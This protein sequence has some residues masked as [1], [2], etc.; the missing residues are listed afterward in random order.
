MIN[1]DA[2]M[3]VSTSVSGV[4]L[5]STRLQESRAA[6]QKGLASTWKSGVISQEAVHDERALLTC[7]LLTPLRTLAGCI[8]CDVEDCS[9]I[10]RV[11][12]AE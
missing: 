10:G 6:S 8:W 2:D 11:V 1:E 7:E 9:D 5:R 3:R 4:M 12:G